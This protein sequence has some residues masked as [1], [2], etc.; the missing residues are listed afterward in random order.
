MQAFG[1]MLVEVN[2]GAPSIFPDF[3]V[4]YSTMTEDAYLVTERRTVD[5]GGLTDHFL[6][7]L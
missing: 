2:M 7:E 3:L 6:G 4:E 1:D 5:A